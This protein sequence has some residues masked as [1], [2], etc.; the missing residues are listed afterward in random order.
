M[1]EGMGLMEQ[2]LYSALA[3]NSTLVSLCP[4]GIWDTQSP[5]GT[6]ATFCLF[7]HIAGGDENLNPRQSISAQYRVEVVSTN[8]GTAIA[9]A[10]AIWSA[11]L[12][13][14]AVAAS[15]WTTWRVEENRFFNSVEDVNGVL[16]YRK[17]AFYTISMDNA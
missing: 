16:W 5:P 2:A 9:G 14:G 3:A 1:A 12:A 7:Q 10:N 6:S 8:R 15:G 11:L 13:S 4:A 17:G